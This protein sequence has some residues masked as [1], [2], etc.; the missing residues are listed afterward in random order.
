MSC[1]IQVS[2][3]CLHSL[4]LC[5]DE[6]LS[7]QVYKIWGTV[8]NRCCVPT[9]FL[10]LINNYGVLSVSCKGDNSVYVKW[11]MFCVI[12]RHIIVVLLHRV[13]CV[14]YKVWKCQGGA[15]EL[16]TFKKELLTL[17]YECALNFIE[18]YMIV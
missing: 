10:L 1:C 4:S 9:K 18:C 7:Y 8:R 11:K 17:Y 14:T 3:W 12:K 2:W 5:W 15:D 6:H 13:L 16:C